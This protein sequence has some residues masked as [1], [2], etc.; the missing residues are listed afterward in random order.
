MEFEIEKILS[1]INHSLEFEG[2]IIDGE[3]FAIN[4]DQGVRVGCI[5]LYYRNPY[6]PQRWLSRVFLHSNAG[7]MLRSVESSIKSCL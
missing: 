7:P 1:K 2:N 6:L 3:Q 4:N 5:I